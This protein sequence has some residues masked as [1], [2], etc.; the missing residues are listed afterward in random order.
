MP[1][2]MRFSQGRELSRGKEID[3]AI[4][5]LKRMDSAVYK[6]FTDEFR[7]KAK[8]IGEELRSRNLP[9]RGSPLSGMAPRTINR[10][11]ATSNADYLNK[12]LYNKPRVKIFI[13][14]RNRGMKRRTR[15]I[16]AI[17]FEAKKGAAGFQIME[18]AGTKNPNGV[19]YR[20][21]NMI[22]GLRTAGF[23]LGDGGRF[24]IPEFYRRR[25]EIMAMAERTLAKYMDRV[26]AEL[27]AKVR[28]KSRFASV[29]SD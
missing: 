8:A 10:R 21:R 25:P 12:Y 23:P 9:Q 13:G 11:R 17:R 29:R 19:S 20:G 14:S 22:E 1:L 6:E 2:S 7:T 4:R 28:R 24:V 27:A 5:T 18:L 15:P 26:S 3:F 16:V